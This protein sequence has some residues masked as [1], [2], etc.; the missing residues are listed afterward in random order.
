MVV[1]R[2]IGGRCTAEGDRQPGI[3]DMA[4]VLRALWLEADRAD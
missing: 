3:A 4:P 2:L 1:I